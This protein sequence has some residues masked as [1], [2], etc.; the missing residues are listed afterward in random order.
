[1]EAS[2]GLCQCCLTLTLTLK[3]SEALA[4]RVRDWTEAVITWS[5]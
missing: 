1:M 5:H 4:L 2:D 3:S